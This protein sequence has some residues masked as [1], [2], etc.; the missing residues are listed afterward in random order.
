MPPLTIAGWGDDHDVSALTARIAAVADSRLSF[1]GPVYGASKQ[2]L[3]AGAAALALPSHSEGLPMVILESWAAGV[4]TAM[5]THC[6]LS[7][8]FDLGAAVDSGTEPQSIAAALS[9]LI[10][11]DATARAAR[12]V[13][14]RSLV[15]ERFAV[16]V[17]RAAWLSAYRQLIEQCA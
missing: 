11:E 10:D 7:E 5:S 17:I 16:P 2:R 1:V 8:G 3:I 4:P 12:S 14:A 15:A 6:H 9:T 13:A